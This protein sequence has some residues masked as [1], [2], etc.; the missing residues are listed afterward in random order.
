MR[1]IIFDL[2]N[3]L[4]PA[5]EVGRQLLEPVFAAVRA[6]HDGTLAPDALEAA[7]EEC[8]FHPLDVVA[9]KHG[10]SDAMRAAGW[11]AYRE[12]EVREPMHGYGDLGLLP[13]LGELRFLVT[14]G[15]QCLQ[16]S[17]VRA[18]RIAPHFA[19][20]VID[21]IDDGDRRGK[22]RIFADLRASFRLARDEVLVVGDDALSELAAARRLGLRSVQILRPGVTPAPDVGAHVSGL[23]E[24]RTLLGATP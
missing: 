7:L 21:A 14:S 3:C 6:A 13:E 9:A 19:A 12:V 17:K 4:A 5:D 22:E 2:D 8:W 18:L 16:E 20:V 1:G 15:V 10:F 23:A 11:R 24:L